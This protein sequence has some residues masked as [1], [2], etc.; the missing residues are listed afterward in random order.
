MSLLIMSKI[1]VKKKDLLSFIGV[2]TKLQR[3]EREGYFIQYE[4]LT[5]T[6]P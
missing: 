5:E 6:L 3:I 2:E 4:V 1:D